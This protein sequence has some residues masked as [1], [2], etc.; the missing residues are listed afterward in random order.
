MHH[1]VGYVKPGYD[2]DVVVWNAHPLTAGASPLQ[3][4]IDGISTLDEVS[5]SSKAYPNHKPPMRADIAP[6]DVKE[7]CSD[8]RQS[9]NLVITGISTSHL[10]HPHIKQSSG[11]NMTMILTNGKIDCLGDYDA[12]VTASFNGRVISLQNGHVL[13]GLTTVSSGLGLVEMPSED[14]TA[15]G[16]GD[17]KANIFDPESALY[18]KYGVHLE[19]KAFDR[20]RVGGVTRSISYPF[21]KGFL[22][23]VSA[24]I[25]T[26]E[27]SNILNG[28]I[29]KDDAAL[30]FVVGQDAKGRLR[31]LIIHSMKSIV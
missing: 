3:V 25:K 14:S 6:N 29:Y 21:S 1:R 30:H 17:S 8:P 9:E 12:C 5:E 23:G 10:K 2:A 15:D 7:L 11:K 4:Y 19:G 28:G 24:G 20:A 31:H 27:D 22:R 13:P 26:A 18:A 16:A